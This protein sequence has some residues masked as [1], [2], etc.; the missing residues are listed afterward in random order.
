MS[1]W[2]I[3]VIE[4][5]GDGQEVV[6]RLLKYHHIAYKIAG[7]GEDALKYLANGGFTACII[8]LSLPGINGWEVLSAIR[9]DPQLYHLPCVA[10]TAYHSA[11]VAMKAVEAGFNA[12][13]SKPLDATSFVR[14]LSRVLESI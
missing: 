13:F 1:D 11:E 2:N 10:I 5:D 8:D 9:H 12:Y 6:L 4:D 14:E 7:T 3:L